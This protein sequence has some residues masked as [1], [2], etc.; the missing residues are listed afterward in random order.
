MTEIK[1]AYCHH[2]LV[3]EEHFTDLVHI[4]GS[5]RNYQISRRSILLEIFN[6]PSIIG[7]FGFQTGKEINKFDSVKYDLKNDMPIVK[8]GCAY[9]VCEVINKM[10]TSTHT[11]FLGKV[12]DADFIS[13]EEPMTYSYY[14]KVIKEKV[15]RMLRH[16]SEWRMKQRKTN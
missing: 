12:L 4:A 11:V 2:L 3:F 10:E 6:E 8:D 14:H 13:D 1:S 16:I 9:L 7:T 5:H 15:P